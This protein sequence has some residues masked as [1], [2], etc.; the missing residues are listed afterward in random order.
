MELSIYKWN[1]VTKI[2]TD[3]TKSAIL[4]TIL[5]QLKN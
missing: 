3:T 1:S 5:Y 2:Q 4:L